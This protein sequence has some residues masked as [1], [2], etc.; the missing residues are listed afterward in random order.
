MLSHAALVGRRSRGPIPLWLL[1]IKGAGL[2][3][4][5][6]LLIV[7]IGEQHLIGKTWDYQAAFDAALGDKNYCE[8]KRDTDAMG[9][10]IEDISFNVFHE[11]AHWNTDYLS[12]QPKCSLSVPK[13]LR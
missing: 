4:F 7:R 13:E 8:A 5:L 2:L 6:Y 12:R 9:D 11:F 3:V 10:A 1:I